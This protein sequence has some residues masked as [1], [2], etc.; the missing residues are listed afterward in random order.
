[1]TG[2]ASV[3]GL[4]DWPCEHAPTKTTAAESM[5]NAARARMCIEYDFHLHESRRPSSEQR[6]LYEG[7]SRDEPTGHHARV[8]DLRRCE[9]QHS[10]RRL[11][12]VLAVGGT[13]AVRALQQ[14][15]WF[16]VRTLRR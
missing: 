1:M 11:D 2:G 3:P 13:P 5:R 14:D 7:S 6:H 10:A 15:G 4:D 12:V 8:V 16:P 9:R